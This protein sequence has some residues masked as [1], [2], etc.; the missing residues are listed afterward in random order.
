MTLTGRGVAL[1]H[2]AGSNA[3]APLIV[4]VGEQ[5]AR[6]GYSVLRFNLP[7]REKRRFGP[8]SPAGAA[9]DRAGI[10]AACARVRAAV[11][12][13]LI[14]AGH[15][16]GGRQASMLLAED[17][18]VA[19]GLLLLSYPLHPPGKPEK[20]R[21][22][23]LPAL[24]TP[25]YFVHGAKDDFGSID[26]MNAAIAVIP[27]PK[28]LQAIA[29]AGHELLKGKFDLAPALEWFDD[30]FAGAAGLGGTSETASVI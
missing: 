30:Y 7:F 29:G 23:H 16:Y 1:T 4:A 10:R 9:E 13:K 21:T 8:P 26:E 11:P 24:R 12:G 28:Y 6:A 25:V 17:P 3:D 27:V 18:S 22:E 20:A 2:G 5:F 14:L 15:S 19:D